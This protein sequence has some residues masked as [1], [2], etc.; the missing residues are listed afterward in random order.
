VTAVIGTEGFPPASGGYRSKN[1]E[2]CKDEY[3]VETFRGG[4]KSVWIDFVEGSTLDALRTLMLA[5]FLTRYEKI[6]SN[7]V[8]LGFGTDDAP[9][10][11]SATNGEIVGEANDGVG[12]QTLI[13]RIAGTTDRGDGSHF[14]ITWSLGNGRTSKESNDVIRLHGWQP[15]EPAVPIHLA[16]ASWIS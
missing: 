6:A 15:I 9:S 10:L 12:V 5:E 16:P 14:H 13:V 3:S 1:A 2:T 11:P 7:H 4:E 8:T